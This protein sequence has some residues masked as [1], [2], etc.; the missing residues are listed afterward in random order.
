MKRL[1]LIV[2]PL[3]LIVGCEEDETPI[4]VE[5]GT[6]TDIEGYEY[7]TVKIGEQWWMAENLKVKHYR[8]GDTIS[9]GHGSIILLS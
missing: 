9:T 2:L 1:L 5:Y 4:E 6:V 8:N 3:L 7:K